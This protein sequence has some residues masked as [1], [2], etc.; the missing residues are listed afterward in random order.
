MVIDLYI[1]NPLEN[2]GLPDSTAEVMYWDCIEKLPLQYTQETTD[3]LL[4]A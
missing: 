2:R 4:V 1:R 3:E